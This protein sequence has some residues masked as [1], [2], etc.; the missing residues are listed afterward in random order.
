MHVY[1]EQEVINHLVDDVLSLESESY[2][3]LA[4]TSNISIS[5]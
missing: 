5:D 3:V 1:F 2:N 4:N